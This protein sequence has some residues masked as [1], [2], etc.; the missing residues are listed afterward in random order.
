[1]R[2]ST[3]NLT[4][5]TRPVEWNAVQTECRGRCPHRPAQVRLHPRPDEWG[6]VILHCSIQRTGWFRG[7]A[8]R[9]GHRPLHFC[10]TAYHS[11]Y[12]SVSEGGGRLVAA[13]TARATANG[14]PPGK[15]PAAP[16]APSWRSNAFLKPEPKYLLKKSA[17][18][19][20][21]RGGFFM[22]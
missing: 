15:A 9:C 21:R 17:P 12:R 4:V 2:T 8:G 13:P 5:S 20:P 3:R 16:W 6:N 11:T 22:L 1:M 18:P 7:V 10:P 14:C 19:M